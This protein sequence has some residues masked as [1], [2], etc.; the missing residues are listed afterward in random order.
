MPSQ[1]TPNQHR[2]V[3]A[4]ER[5][6]AILET[7]EE[8]GGV[9]VSEL[10]EHVDLAK[11]TVHRYLVTME[12]CGY[13]VKEGDMYH[14]GLRFLEL[15]EYARSRKKAY[16]MAEPKVAELARETNERA[17]FIVEEHG[18]AVYIHRAFGEHAIRTD[19]GIGKRI[20]VHATSAG[21]AIL[22]H[23]PNI[24]TEQIIEEQ[25]LASITD[26]TI[27][28]PDELWTELE[29]VRE[30]GYAINNQ[31]NIQGLRAVGVPVI[32]PADQVL[33]AFS[34]SGPIH[35]MEEER[36]ENELLSLLMGT[37]NELEL[38]LMHGE[39]SNQSRSDLGR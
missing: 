33:G 21:K 7:I 13:L 4:G 39:R 14:V 9:R 24:R 17:Q 35:R 8:L 1:S 6:F 12:E 34:V 32:G 20:P 18:A 26:Y 23:M 5:M 29:E 31:E 36:L 25:G 16:P 37:A 22:A 28:N 38:N 2:T 27:T 10:A 3:K 30:Q 19:P 15:G 11:S